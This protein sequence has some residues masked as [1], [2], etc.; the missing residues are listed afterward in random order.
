MAKIR[1]VIV[2]GDRQRL[3]EG[4][5]SRRSRFLHRDHEEDG[6]V[7][8]LLG[9][10]D[11]GIQW[12]GSAPSGEFGQIVHELMERYPQSVWQEG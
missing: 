2:E 6:R 8:C 7:L 11:G 10:H 12:D 3:Q 5:D 1:A 4:A 9:S